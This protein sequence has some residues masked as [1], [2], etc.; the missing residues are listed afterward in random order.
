MLSWYLQVWRRQGGPK[1]SSGKEALERLVVNSDNAL[2]GLVLEHRRLCQAVAGMLSPL[3]GV[4]EP[5]AGGGSRLF[6]TVTTHTAT[7]RVSLL[8]PNLQ[9]L[10]RDWQLE[11]T[12]SLAKVGSGLLLG[13]TTV[14]PRSCVVPRSRHLLLSADYSQLELR[15]L[16][17]LS[18]DPALCSTLR[19]GGDVFRRV[20]ARLNNCAEE[21]VSDTQRQQAKQTVYGVLY[22]LGDRGLASQL[23]L[24][25]P[26]AGQ[27]A[28][29]FR[30]EYPGVRGWHGRTVAG[31]R[32][33]G[34][35]TTLAGRLRLLPD[36]QCSNPARRAAAERQ[37]VNTT[38]QVDITTHPVR[39]LCLLCRA[40][41]RTW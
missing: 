34:G 10:P 6:P 36:L 7:G 41:R 39:L 5:Q 9:N 38:V 22:G 35:A 24:T 12:A 18:Q 3:L 29:Q 15:L 14:S 32:Q 21:I 16:A 4:A 33:A 20:A 23:G 2:P 25:P 27:V 30:C 26:Q 37:A 19:Q 31:S 40:A 28:E 1:P 17:H 11:V 13:T 8:E